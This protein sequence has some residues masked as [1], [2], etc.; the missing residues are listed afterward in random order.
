MDAMRMVLVFSG[1][2]LLSSCGS[3]EQ[4]SASSAPSAAP[5]SASAPASAPATS[6]SPT[7][8]PSV[9]DSN[10][11]IV[12]VFF[13]T[14]RNK[15]K[16]T[17]PSEMFGSNRSSL[18]YGMCDVSIPRDHRMGELEYPAIWKFEFRE[19]P[20]RHVVLLN[21][22]VES[23]EKFFSDVAHRVRQS[24]ASSALLFIHGYNV[25]FEDA[26]RRTAQITYD[27]GFEGAATFYSWP[28]RG[29]VSAYTIDEQNVEWTQSNLKNFLEDF[30][31]Q[32]SAENVYL[33]AHSMGNRALVRAVTSL[34]AE[35]PTLQNRLKEVILTAPDIDADVFK[36]D[37]VPALTSSAR[38]VT[39]YASSEDRA[40]A[41]S[42]KIHGYLRAGDSGQGLV[43]VP[44]VETIDASNVD[45]SF[46][47]HSYFAEERSVLSDIF[48]LVRNEQKADQ[49]FGLRFVDTQA[50]RYWEFKR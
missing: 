22:V 12:R 6:A 7:S 40:L 15:T 47:G 9:I 46:L 17:K 43:V 5:A 37:I 4:P 24:K 39:L 16:S 21:T 36:R 25:T 18:A 3:A 1:L 31:V 44:G 8:V 35:K 33:I 14:D 2:V 42:K 38:S 32:S 11:A 30:L 27:L 48:Y 10:Y 41:A 23:K 49:R 34:L 28:S 29:T 19:N 45:T 26:A 20:E 13:A 50:G